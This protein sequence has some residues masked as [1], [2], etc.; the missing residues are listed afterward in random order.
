[1]LT[2]KQVADF[3]TILRGILG[4]SLVWLGISEGEAGLQKAV[5]IMIAAWTGDAVDG[6]IARRSKIYYHTWLGDHDLEVDMTVSCGLLVYLITANYINI[7]IASI[8]VIFW[9]LVIWRWRDFNVLGMLSQAPIYGYFIWVAVT[10]LPNVG[11]WV[12]VFLLLVII[13]TWPQFPKQVVPGFFKGIREF[14]I[15]R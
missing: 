15:N 1:M 6:K 13:V 2:A 10:R 11:I 5:L 4:L 3:V 14:W 8:Y 12:L 7:W 9:A